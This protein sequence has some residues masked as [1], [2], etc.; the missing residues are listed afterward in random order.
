V[1]V[2]PA[3]LLNNTAVLKYRYAHV[4]ARRSFSLFISSVVLRTRACNGWKPCWRVALLRLGLKVEAEYS[5][6]EG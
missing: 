2:V 3:K 1:P 5:A 4:P 6:A